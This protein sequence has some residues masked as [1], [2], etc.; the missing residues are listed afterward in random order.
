MSGVWA[1][2]LQLV[3][4]LAEHQLP[5]CL[6]QPDPQ[7]CPAALHCASLP[8][9]PGAANHPLWSEAREHPPLQSQTKCN[10]DRGFWE[11]V[12]DGAEGKFDLGDS[13]L[14]LTCLV[15]TNAY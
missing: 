9:H 5:R 13:V 12:S 1:T 11:F 4:P 3:R 6:S 8:L 10:Q 2:V 7:V 15:S 14:V